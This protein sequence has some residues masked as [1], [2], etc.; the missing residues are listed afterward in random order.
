MLGV[1]TTS[2]GQIAGEAGICYRLPTTDL[3]LTFGIVPYGMHTRV[4]AYGIK[5]SDVT[6]TVSFSGAVSL[7]SQSPIAAFGGLYTEHVLQL[8]RWLPQGSKPEWLNNDAGWL[9]KRSRYLLEFGGMLNFKH[10]VVALTY[11]AGLETD[12]RGMTADHLKDGLSLR[13][14]LRY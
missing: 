13:A 14:Y 6:F 12:Y 1:N 9:T 3:M 11:R 10:L 8:T 5:R 4:D 7:S 2:R